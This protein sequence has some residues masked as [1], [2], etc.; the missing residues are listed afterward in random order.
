MSL[1]AVTEREPVD[2]AER[3]E[4]LPLD[5][6]IESGHNP[7]SHFDPA[8]LAQLAASIREKGIIEP[9]VVRPIDVP[10]ATRKHPDAAAR[11][12][13]HFEIVAGA[14]RFRAA[15][16]AGLTHAPCVIRAYSD[17]DVLELTLIENIQRDDLRPLEQAR[18]Y[19]ALIDANPT[20]HT[21]ATIAVRVG[22]SEAW[23]WDRLKLLDLIPAAKQI[24]EQDRMSV[25]HAILIAR[26]KPEDQTRVIDPVINRNGRDGLWQGDHAGL[27]WDEDDPANAKRQ[28]GPYDGLKAVSIRELEHWIADHVRFDVAHAAQAVP[29]EFA[30]TAARVEQAVA[31]PGR[32][33]K[34]IPITFDY[35][36]AD[37]AR[38][39]AERTYGSESWK[40]ADGQEKSKTCEHS[41]LGVVVAGDRQ[42]GQTLQVCVARDACRVH[43]GAV[44]KAKEQNAK[45]RDQGKG[46][47]AAKNEQRGEQRWQV[48]QRKRQEERARWDRLAPHAVAAAV[49]KTK[50]GKIT[51]GVLRRAADMFDVASL[52]E[53][54]H[55]LGG[56]ITLA[57]FSRA[58]EVVEILERRH[59]R[60]QFTRIAKK[61]KLD[62][63][64][65]EKAL[66]AP[67]ADKKTSSKG[68]K[69][70]AA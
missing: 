14:R 59:S 9:L 5:Q 12:G 19:R 1:S 38:D 69:A 27:P 49:A 40:R 37:D 21:A 41:V 50:T 16:T 30:E 61:Y 55:A 65:L 34:V 51:N 7:R 35:R 26:L 22:M 42:Y 31:K 66:G 36:V 45:L 10:K 47:Q 24:L 29:L 70:S 58:L 23:V 63:V 57:T 18:G 32:G 62:L 28:R 53:I 56:R 20:K 3:F 43:F 33:K 25:G 67:A 68:G 13:A 54:E 6:L 15:T 4:L 60:D 39:E 52:T 2:E 17:E 8:K 46:K 64:K 11:H 48:E 44:I